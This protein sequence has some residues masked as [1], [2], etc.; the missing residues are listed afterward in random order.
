MILIRSLRTIALAVVGFN[1]HLNGYSQSYDF[2]RPIEAIDAIGN[3]SFHIGAST[4]NETVTI[5]ASNPSAPT[6]KH[7]GFLTVPTIA[8]PAPTV[9]HISTDVPASFPNPGHTVFGDLTLAL[10]FSSQPTTFAIDTGA[11]QMHWNGSAWAYTVPPFSKTLPA[12]LSYTLT[13]DNQ[14][15]TGIQPVNIWLH[16]TPGSTIDAS[17]YPLSIGLDDTASMWVAPS[18]LLNFTA[19]NGLHV[20]ATVAVVPEPGVVA[21]SLV[22]FGALIL[23][24]RMNPMH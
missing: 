14:T 7:V 8:S 19:P 11:T 20:L 24:R 16:F 3:V 10:S 6:I 18:L 1:L 17:N 21:I 13:T 12:T 22:C 23:R 15:Y 4:F 5:D 9:M 2:L